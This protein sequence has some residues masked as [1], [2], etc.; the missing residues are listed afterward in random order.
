MYRHTKRL[1]FYKIRCA[2]NFLFFFSKDI[3]N[4]N[5]NGNITFS[6]PGRKPIKI[7]RYISIPAKNVFN[8][9]FLYII[10]EIS[11]S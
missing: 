8:T 4:E 1:I 7:L 5:V 9:L 6:N 2:K 10:L 3:I 11:V